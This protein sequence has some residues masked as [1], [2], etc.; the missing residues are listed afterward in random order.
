MKKSVNGFSTCNSA[1]PILYLEEAR[2]KFKR[3]FGINISASYICKI[4]HDNNFSWKSL[5]VRAIEI[6]DDEIEKF[7]Y[8][9]NSI[10]WHYTSLVFFD[11]VSV[12]NHGLIRKKGYGIVGK[13]LIFRDEFNR[14]P[15][16]SLLCFLGQESF[17]ETHQT[18][19]TFSRQK[20]FDCCK[21]FALSVRFTLDNTACGYWMA[22]RSI[23][24]LRT[25][26]I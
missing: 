16:M 2:C 20:F 4:L 5:E 24:I 18:E 15:R 3:N 19:G 25:Y 12:D 11:E 7:F 13:K 1:C 10:E 23:A 6:K 26:V 22:P 17:L 21:N 8:E 9:L 14:K